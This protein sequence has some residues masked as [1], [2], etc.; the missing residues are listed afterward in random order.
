MW[1]RP[2]NRKPARDVSSKLIAIITRICYD[3]AIYGRRFSSAS[4][5]M[6]L[7]ALV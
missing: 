3:F 7:I 2:A 6:A 5:M 1:R 4:S